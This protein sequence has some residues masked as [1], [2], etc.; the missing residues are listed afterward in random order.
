MA[1][2]HVA[3]SLSN[4]LES[5]FFQGGEDLARFERTELGIYK[6]LLHTHKLDW[7]LLVVILQSKCHS[8][9]HILHEFING[10]AL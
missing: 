1:E 4:S 5:G 2:P 10:P 6:K 8:L 7:L 9:F 3:A